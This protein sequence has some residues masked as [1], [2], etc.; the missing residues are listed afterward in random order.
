MRIP[1]T[2]HSA[3]SRCGQRLVDGCETVY[4]RI[5]LCNRT[6]KLRKFLREGWIDEAGMAGTTAVVNQTN[7]WAD[8][9]FAQTLQSLIRPRPV[10]T[11][12]TVGCSAL[13]QHWVA[14]GAYP[15]FCK[16]V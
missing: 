2:I 5:T 4:P 14:E 12:L 8:A 7:D 3:K 6:G 11:H 16:Q 10:S 9:E 13:P 1:V 15:K